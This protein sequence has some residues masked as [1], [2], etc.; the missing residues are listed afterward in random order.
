V[1]KRPDL[2][3][4]KLDTKPI[5]NAWKEGG[6]RAQ[7]LRDRLSAAGG[8]LSDRI[9]DAYSVLYNSTAITSQ[10]ISESGAVSRGKVHRPIRPSETI[11]NDV[12]TGAVF[13]VVMLLMI[14]VAAAVFFALSSTFPSFAAP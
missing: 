2:R 7:S 3:N 10:M 13:L 5:T 1:N 12:S 8:R 4:A 14:V 9:G 6:E 11:D